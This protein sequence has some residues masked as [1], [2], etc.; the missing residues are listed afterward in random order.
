M[1]NPAIAPAPNTNGTQFFIAAE[2]MPEL[3]GRHTVF[4]GCEPTN[5]ILDI[6]NVPTEDPESE[7]PAD[8][9]ALE[10]VVIHR[11]DRPTPT[12]DQ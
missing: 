8:P 10:R 6:S 12:T 1:P 9:P 3:D 7:R 4:G 11:G 2:A 5:V